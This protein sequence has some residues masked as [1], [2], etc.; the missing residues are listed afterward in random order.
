MGQVYGFC[1]DWKLSLLLL[2]YVMA[3]LFALP[4]QCWD[5]GVT[6][7]EESNMMNVNGVGK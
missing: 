5:K 4:N 3:H 6:G 2:H 7:R 1:N